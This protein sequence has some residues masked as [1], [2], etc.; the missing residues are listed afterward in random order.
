[1]DACDAVMERTGRPKGLIR[2]DSDEGI[3]T[4]HHSIFNARS[5]AYSVVLTLLIFFVA[6]MFALRGD[7]ETTIL[8]ARGTLYQEYGT[9]S[10]S[11]IYTIQVVNKV[12]NPVSIQL[13]VLSH[14]GHVRYIMD[15]GIIEEG[16][17]G[18]GQFMVVI[19]KSDLN[20][21]KTDIVIG[22]HSNGELIEEY[23]SAFIGP[24]Y[25]DKH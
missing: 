1:M 14:K 11:N 15:P 3:E 9:D 16:T 21:S 19:A 18:K 10:I 5:I 22:I 23:K 7:S 20:S 8:R 4:G 24:Q 12:R 13:D 2:Y 17:V 6:A 25:L